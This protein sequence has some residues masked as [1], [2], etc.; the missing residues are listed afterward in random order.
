MHIPFYKYQGT[1][2]DFILVDHREGALGAYTA[3]LVQ[4]LCHRRLGIGADGLLLLQNAPGYDFEVIYHNADGS[5]GMCGNGSRCAVHFAARLGMITKAAHFLA[6]DGP[7]H[8]QIKDDLIHLK[9]NDVP[10]VQTLEEDYWVNTGSPHY[11]KLVNDLEG[12]D[13]HKAGQEIRHSAPFQKEGINVNFVRLEG[14][15]KLSMRTYERGVEGE[16][17][18]C[19]TGATAA[20]LVAATKGHKSPITIHTQ[21]GTLRVSFTQDNLRFQDICLIGPTRQVFQGKVDVR[22]LAPLH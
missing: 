18:S 8:A 13:V 4:K 16:T 22:C 17:L 19:G 20:A 5:Q 12:L 15:S 7:H 6:A 14:E 9:L 1:G 21:G 10:R 2:N 3:Q 11:V